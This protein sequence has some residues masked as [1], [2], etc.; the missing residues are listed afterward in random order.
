MLSEN[1]HTLPFFQA[2]KRGTGRMV[3]EEENHALLWESNS[4]SYFISC[5]DE[6]TA[7]ALAK[8][9]PPAELILALEE[10]TARIFA[11]HWALKP[12]VKFLQTVYEKGEPLPL[13]GQTEIRT[14]SPEYAPELAARYEHIPEEDYFRERIAAGQCF[15]AFRQG[16]WVGFGGLHDEGSMGFLEVFPIHRRQGVGRDL[17]SY[18][19]NYHLERGWTPFAHAFADNAASLTLQ[20]NLGF[21]VCEQPVYWCF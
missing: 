3:S 12:Q 10:H 14:L 18:I 8:T 16:Q 11:Q 7:L 1:T 19:V 9:T 5:K 2:L 4:R 20:R 17:L 13:S 15:G 21:T 6:E